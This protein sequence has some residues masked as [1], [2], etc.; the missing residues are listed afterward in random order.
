VL[1]EDQKREQIKTNEANIQDAEVEK[2]EE[3]IKKK[4]EVEGFFSR[5]KPYNKPVINVWIA[6]FVSVI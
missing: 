4:L 3:D 6:T 1:T 2:V 5:L